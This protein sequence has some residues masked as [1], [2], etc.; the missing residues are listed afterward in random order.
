[1][2]A[3]N[4]PERLRTGQYRTPD[5]LRA[6]IALHERYSTNTRDWQRFVFE[7][8]LA[9]VPPN[10]SVLEVGASPAELWRRNLDRVPP[11]W[12]ITL[13]DFSPGMV[14]AERTV[15]ASLAERV[16][17][18][19]ADAR[20][21]PFPDGAF[22]AAVANHMLYHV[23]NRPKAL[24]ELR[25]VLKPGGTLLAA[26]NG[27]GHVRELHALIAPYLPVRSR[28]GFDD[29]T[30][31]NG[32]AQL[33]PFFQTVARDDYEDALLVTNAEPL[34][35]YIDS[36]LSRELLPADARAT[37]ERRIR[38]EI[39]RHGAFHIATETGLFIART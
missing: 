28:E 35:A 11:G 13:S 2:T 32:A 1:M 4:D 36:M 31:E 23:P 29:F 7:H 8:L 37:L 27:E 15:T 34:L 17:C 26:T 12:R 30:L 19:V 20:A 3:L 9:A 22:D 6:R 21:L 5:N 24:A 18:L 33:A 38:D 16:T 10:G 25:R 14:E 39:A